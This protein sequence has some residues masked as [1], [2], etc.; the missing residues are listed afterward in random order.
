[1]AIVCAYGPVDETRE[2]P[3]GYC[4]PDGQGSMNGSNTDKTLKWDFSSW[5]PTFICATNYL[6]HHLIPQGPVYRLAVSHDYRWVASGSSDGTAY[7]GRSLSFY[8]LDHKDLVIL[9]Q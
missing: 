6:H 8:K 3:Y 4:V 1:M 2:G 5:I 7:L 9:V